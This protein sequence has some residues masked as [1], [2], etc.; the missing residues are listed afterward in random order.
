MF[1]ASSENYRGRVLRFLRFPNGGIL[2]RTMDI[3]LIAGISGRDSGVLGSHLNLYNA[4]SVAD[5]VDKE[6]AAWLSRKFAAYDS[7]T[8]ELDD[9]VA[10]S[11]SFPDRNLKRTKAGKILLHLHPLSKRRQAS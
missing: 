7:F 11:V 9:L 2:F 8:E 5:T 4:V 3:C 1:E 6:F 10:W